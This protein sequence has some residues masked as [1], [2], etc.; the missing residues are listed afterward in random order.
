MNSGIVEIILAII[1]SG[2]LTSLV[3]GFFQNKKHKE[4][5]KVATEELIRDMM[6]NITER[7]S[8]RESQFIEDMRSQIVELREEVRDNKNKYVEILNEKNT[9]ELE[10][11]KIYLEYS[12]QIIGLEKKVNTL[13]RE[14]E[15]LKFRLRELTRKMESQ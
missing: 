13:E 12:A 10:R 15:D 6:K 9:I 7:Q 4:D 8:E 2:V 1:A 11:N 14:K 3:T 5:R